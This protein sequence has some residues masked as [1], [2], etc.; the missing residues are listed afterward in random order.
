MIYLNE[1]PRKGEQN[2]HRNLTCF[3]Y[4]RKNNVQSILLYFFI[5]KIG[6]M[7]NRQFEQQ[8]KKNGWKIHRFT[9]YE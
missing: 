6:V 9:K 2:V 1:I 7:T 8:N 5:K 4:K 3:P